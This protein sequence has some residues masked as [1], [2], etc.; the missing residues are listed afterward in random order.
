MLP[1]INL[2]YTQ[3]SLALGLVPAAG[4]HLHTG[5]LCVLALAVLPVLAAN[6]ATLGP[7]SPPFMWVAGSTSSLAYGVVLLTGQPLGSVAAVWSGVS[8]S[9]GRAAGADK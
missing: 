7:S 2:L 5:V 9:G 8:A 4:S 3:L 1:A 6:R